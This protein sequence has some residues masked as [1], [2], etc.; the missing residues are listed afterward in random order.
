MDWYQLGYISVLCMVSGLMKIHHINETHLWRQIIT[1]KWTILTAIGTCQWWIIWCFKIGFPLRINGWT[2]KH[3]KLCRDTPTNW[4][5]CFLTI[6]YYR[7]DHDCYLY[8]FYLFS[9]VKIVNTI[10]WTAGL[11]KYFLENKKD[12]PSLLW[13]YFGSADGVYRVYPG[14]CLFL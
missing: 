13:Q 2:F 4:L 12:E 10:K 14:R 11:E 6:T 5:I 9:G 3:W 1:R 8:N 7:Y